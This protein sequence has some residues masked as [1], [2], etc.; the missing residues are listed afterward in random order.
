[1][2]ETQFTDIIS[3]IKNARTAALKTVKVILKL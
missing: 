3:L 1:M 2:L